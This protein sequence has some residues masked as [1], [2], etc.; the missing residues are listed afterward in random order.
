MQLKDIISTLMLSDFYFSLPLWER[1]QVV[2]RLWAS[3][4]ARRPLAS[5]A[6]PAPN[7][8]PERKKL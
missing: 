2:S 3:H 5:L 8:L 1:K 7:D 4:G 6:L